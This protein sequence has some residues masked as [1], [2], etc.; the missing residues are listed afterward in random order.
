MDRFGCQEGFTL[1]EMVTAIFL[2]VVIIAAGFTVLSGTT[3]AVRANNQT[4]D[5]QQ[6]IRVAMNLLARDIK[7]AG[8]GIVSQVGNCAV[9]GPK[10]PD[11]SPPLDDFFR[12][13]F[14]DPDD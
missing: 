5:L 3:R 13:F 2:A 12:H 8:F 11:G 1:I 7:V 4:V 9:G 10:G 14:G 6:N